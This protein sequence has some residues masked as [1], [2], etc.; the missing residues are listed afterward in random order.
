MK[1]VVLLSGG[2]DSTTCL[3]MAVAKYGADEVTALTVLYG[4]K[5]FKE[6]NSAMQIAQHYGVNHIIKELNN[7]FELA[8]DN[9]MLAG[10]A[11]IRHESYAE[12]LSKRPGTVDTYVP[13]RNGLLLSFATAIAYSLGASLIVYGAHADDAAGQAYPDCTPEFYMGMNNAIK[14]GTAGK[15]SLF[16]P[17]ISSNKAGVVRAGLALNAPYEL[18]WSCYEGG[19]L[20][21][22]TCGTCIDR[23][24]AFVANNGVDPIIY[25]GFNG[26]GKKGFCGDL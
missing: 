5:H 3:A 25:Q 15:V 24:A 10:G 13:F 8:T 22:G 18:T 14:Y 20:A 23:L 19:D 12:Q 16:A 1:A 4:Q 7:V 6:I 17:L 26:I 21:C 11:P 2:I 9:P